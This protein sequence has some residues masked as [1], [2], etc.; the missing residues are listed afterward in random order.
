MSA[1]LLMA[2]ALPV[3][4]QQSNRPELSSQ[5][6]QW[7][8]KKLLSHSVPEIGVE[9]ARQQQDALF[10]DAREPEEFQVSRIP[11][12]QFAGYEQFDMEP[13]LQ[14]DKNQPI[15]IYCSVGYRSEKVAEQFLAEGFSQV[16][17]LYGGIFEWVNRGYDVWDEQNQPTDK[18]HAYSKSWGWLLS[19]GQKVYAP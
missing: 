5:R 13:W 11:G 8:L 15:I 3:Q 2:S 10:L 18:I 7:T 12:A 1:L 6:F 17:N 9:Q 16:H 19:R 14:T 4:A